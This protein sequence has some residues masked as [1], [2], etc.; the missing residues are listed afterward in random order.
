[1]AWRTILFC[2]CAISILLAGTGVAEPL[3]E[4][5]PRLL[6]T[7]ADLVH[8]RASCKIPISRRG[9]MR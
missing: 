2:V 1:M 4:A 8:A 9:S 5:Q 6:L 3:G 7:P